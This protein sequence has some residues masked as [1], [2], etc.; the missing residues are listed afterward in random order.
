MLARQDG[1]CAEWA[2]RTGQARSPLRQ[3]PWQVHGAL[4][5]V[6]QMNSAANALARIRP[7][8]RVAGGQRGASRSPSRVQ[9]L[10]AVVRARQ[11][12]PA[13]CGPNHR[14]GVRA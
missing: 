7:P 12:V 14:E 2:G 11:S 13:T 4:P 6:V 5:V 3:V 9:G 10:R 1:H 8:D